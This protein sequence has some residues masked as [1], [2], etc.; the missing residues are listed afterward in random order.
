MLVLAWPQDDVP[1]FLYTKS[2]RKQQGVNHV[3]GEIL[4]CLDLKRK[5]K[6]FTIIV[7]INPQALSEHG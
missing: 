6:G 3:V 2:C 5:R 4:Y 1:P 7:Q